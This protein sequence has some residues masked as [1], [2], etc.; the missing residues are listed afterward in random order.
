MV[1][2]WAVFTFQHVMVAGPFNDIGTC[3]QV[4]MQMHAIG[5]LFC[6]FF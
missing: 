4:I 5:Q 3:N 2:Q 6:G 1:T